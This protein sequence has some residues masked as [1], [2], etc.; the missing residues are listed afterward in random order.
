MN[1][2]KHP[3]VTNLQKKKSIK[4]PKYSYDNSY[5][6]TYTESQKTNNKSPRRMKSTKKSKKIKGELK[7]TIASG[8]Y[9]LYVLIFQK[10][11]SFYQDF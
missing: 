9:I 11:T 8:N 5:S 7:D 2:I 6:G 1:K 4:K 3:I 10:F